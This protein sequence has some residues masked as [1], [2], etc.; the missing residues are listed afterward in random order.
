MYTI[1]V[2]VP[3]IIPFICL[4][5]IGLFSF[6]NPMNIL[7]L[8][9]FSRLFVSRAF[10]NEIVVPIY[11]S[12]FLTT[13]LSQIPSVIAPVMHEIV[14][15]NSCP[16]LQTWCGGEK[17]YF[18]RILFYSYIFFGFFKQDRTMFSRKCWKE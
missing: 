16:R 12:T 3:P 13:N 5:F 4:C 6:L 8:E 10:W 15:L 17:V 14:P 11:S 9:L 7:P 2:Q 1:Q 18:C